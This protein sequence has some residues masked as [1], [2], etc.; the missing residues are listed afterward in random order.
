MSVGRV[1]MFLSFRFEETEYPCA[2]VEWFTCS[3]DAPDEETGLWVV[4]PL[5][6]LSGKRA[7]DVIH[8]DS[9][10]RPVHLLPIFGSEPL[11]ENFHFSDSL[12]AFRAF[13]VNKLSNH[14]SYEYIQ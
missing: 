8:L 12:D 6:E 3:M 2:L 10:A 7:L 9:I 1:K 5:Y 4:E 11:P 13:F 14:A